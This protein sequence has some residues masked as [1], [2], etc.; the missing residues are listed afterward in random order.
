MEGD[1]IPTD[2]EAAQCDSGRL[3][4]STNA[5]GLSQLA[6]KLRCGSGARM[7]VGES[8]RWYRQCSEF[9]DA[10]SMEHLG[11]CYEKG[12]GVEIDL[13]ESAKYIYYER[14]F[15]LGSRTSP[16]NWGFLRWRDLGGFSVDHVEA[17][18]LWRLGGRSIPDSA[19]IAD[20]SGLISCPDS[21]TGSSRFFSST[22]RRKLSMGAS[23]DAW[24]FVV[25]SRK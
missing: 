2:E 3:E 23:G 4:S 9:G 7:D 11:N 5:T 1:V 20:R 8:L 6:L 17:V 14:A 24:T 13:K 12:F 19:V 10:V 22:H 15:E 21:G 25:E 18:R 16:W